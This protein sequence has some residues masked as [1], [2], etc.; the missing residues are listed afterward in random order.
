MIRGARAATQ[1]LPRRQCH[2]TPGF[3]LVEV[4]VAL[5]IEWINRQR[6]ALSL[7]AVLGLGGIFVEILK[8]A[9][10]RV[11]PLSADDAH[12]IIHERAETLNF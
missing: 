9:V 1:V 12:E 8:D 2:P 11:P 5:A 3:T 10:L 6:M 7:A 4:L